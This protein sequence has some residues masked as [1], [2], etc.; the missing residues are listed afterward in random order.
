MKTRNKIFLISFL[1]IGVLL[2]AQIKVVSGGNVGIGVTSPNSKLDVYVAPTSSGAY[3]FGS[4]M[5]ATSPTLSIWQTTGSPARTSAIYNN[6]G[7]EIFRSG[8]GAPALWFNQ[9]NDNIGIGQ[10]SSSAK[11]DILNSNNGYGF[12]VGLGNSDPKISIWQTTSTARTSLIYENGAFEIYNQAGSTSEFYVNTSGKVGIGTNSPSPSYKLTVNGS[13]L[14][15]GGTWTNSDKRYKKNIMPLENALSKL[16]S[17][18]GVVYEFRTDEYKEMNFN[19][20]KSIGF[21]AQDLEKV[22]PEAVRKDDKGFYAVNYDEI[23]PVLVEAIKEQ[24]KKAEE[25]QKANDELKNKVDKLEQLVKSCCSNSSMGNNNTNTSDKMAAQ[26]NINLSDKNTIVLN[27][28]VPNPFA[29]NTVVTFNI[30]NTFTKAQV[31]F[32]TSDGKVINTFDIKEKGEGRLNVF[33][34]D[35]SSGMYTYTLV[36]DGKT[37]DTKKMIKN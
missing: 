17:L 21:I 24:D 5:G 8:S 28:N 9:S 36:V 12:I 2:K 11:L 1:S 10:R 23:I 34:N 33:A 19:S 16:K 20:G 27:Q 13:A 30:P 32:S 18:N 6:G 25:Q 4:G 37:I 22:I 26:N 31:F 35:L 7:F 29:E 15:I 14:A 3:T